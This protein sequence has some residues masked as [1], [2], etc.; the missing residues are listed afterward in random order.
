MGTT[1]MGNHHETSM[2]TAQVVVN[3]LLKP[4][5][6]SGYKAMPQLHILSMIIRFSSVGLHGG[7]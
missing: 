5:A 1:G 3:V 7:G 2:C 4:G 6:H